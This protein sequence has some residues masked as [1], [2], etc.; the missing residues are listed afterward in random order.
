MWKKYRDRLTLFDDF[1]NFCEC[2]DLTFQGLLVL[3]RQ[4][5]RGL[6]EQVLNFDFQIR[7]IFVLIAVSDFLYRINV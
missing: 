4:P 5:G 2:L 1:R 7:V 6:E 3:E